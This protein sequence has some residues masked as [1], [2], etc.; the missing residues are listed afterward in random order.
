MVP[1]V[2]MDP[3]EYCTWGFC[4]LMVNSGCALGPLEASV[5]GSKTSIPYGR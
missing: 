1:R 2:G 5:L 3:G 4:N